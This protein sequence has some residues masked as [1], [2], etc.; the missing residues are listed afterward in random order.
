MKLFDK[1]KNLLTKTQPDTDN[2]PQP[3]N[4]SPHPITDRITTWLVAQDWHYEHRKPN[5]KTDGRTHHVILTFTDNSSDWTCV[6]RINEQNQLVAMFGVLAQTVPP[7]HYAPMLMK[8]AHANLNIAF[9]SI[10]LDPTDGEVRVKMSVD[11]EF[12]TLSDKALACYLQGLSGLTEL[13]G[14]LFN[15]VVA[16]LEPS[17]IVHDYLEMPDELELH[18][19]GEFFIPTHQAQ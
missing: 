4:S 12:S 11:A 15:E 16:E 13:A 6:F 5:P 2:N 8:I 7:S 1:L 17:P 3:S 18:S 19:D 14:R 10:E 9:G